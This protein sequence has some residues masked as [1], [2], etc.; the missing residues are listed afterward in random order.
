MI[1]RVEDGYSHLEL[2]IRTC[3][4]ESP[5]GPTL[6]SPRSDLPH[7]VLYFTGASIYD[8]SRLSGLVEMVVICRISPVYVTV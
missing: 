1:M 7:R 8:M 3:S 4:T 2:T 5:A 6:P